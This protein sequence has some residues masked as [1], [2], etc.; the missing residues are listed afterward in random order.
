MSWRATRG[1]STLFTK[2]L[3]KSRQRRAGWLAMFPP[4]RPGSAQHGDLREPGV[5]F[6]NVSQILQSNLTKIFNARIYVYGENFMLKLC[7]R[8]QSMALGTCIKFQLEIIVSSLWFRQN[9]NFERIFLKAREMLVK[10]P[11]DMLPVFPGNGMILILKKTRMWTYHHP[12][13]Q[14]FV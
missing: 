5:C 10:Q 6:T 1:Y 12:W 3:S 8:D 13:C 9:T 7:T 14:Q 2:R 11:L 4:S